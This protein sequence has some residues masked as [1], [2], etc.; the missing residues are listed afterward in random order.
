[1]KSG[2]ALALSLSATARNWLGAVIYCYLLVV[3]GVADGVRIRAT[4]CCAVF[5]VGCRPELE[6]QLARTLA[7]GAF[8]LVT[9]RASLQP[10]AHK[11]LHLLHDWSGL[12]DDA[13]GCI[14]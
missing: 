8:R 5:R 3:S 7:V 1:M 4:V 2:E 13:V 12:S 11:D 14:K 6:V 9:R 10:Q